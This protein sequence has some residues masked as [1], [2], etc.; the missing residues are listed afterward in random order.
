MQQKFVFQGRH[1]KKRKNMK[2][3]PYTPVGQH[4]TTAPM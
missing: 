2:T 3:T 4:V 1:E